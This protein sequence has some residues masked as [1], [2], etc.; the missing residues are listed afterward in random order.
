MRI[1]FPYFKDYNKLDILL[2]SI[3]EFSVGKI[4]PEQGFLGSSLVPT[5]KS[6]LRVGGLS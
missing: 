6:F 2:T 3:N 5:E 1:P 4:S